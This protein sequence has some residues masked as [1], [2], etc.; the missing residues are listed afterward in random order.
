[1]TEEESLTSDQKFDIQ[2]LQLQRIYDVLLLLLDEEDREK[3]IEGHR[4]FEFLG[5][6]PWMEE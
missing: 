3:L 6:A 4:K 1:M 5:P 2:V